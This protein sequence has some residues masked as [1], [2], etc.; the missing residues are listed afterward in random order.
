MSA[1]T[2]HAVTVVVVAP[3]AAPAPQNVPVPPATP[4][5]APAVAPAAG[6]RAST[7]WAVTAVLGLA[8]TGLV[9][10][11]VPDL[12]PVVD[13]IVGLAAVL[14]AWRRR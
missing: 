11:Q 8:V 4:A 13:S 5:P 10:H 14:F 12:V 7:R 6:K 3:A 1:F 9:L 2:Q